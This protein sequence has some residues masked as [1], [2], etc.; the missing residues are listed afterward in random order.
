MKAIV[1]QEGP[2][3]A[4]RYTIALEEFKR[5]RSKVKS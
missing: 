4:Q 3:E 1:E 2:D 5:K